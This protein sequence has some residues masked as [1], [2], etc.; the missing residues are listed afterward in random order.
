MQL[1]QE[2]IKE[3]HE[4]TDFVSAL[5]E[6]LTGYGIIASDF[7]GNIIAFNKGAHQIYGYTPLEVIGKRN[8]DIFLPEDFIN[9]GKLQKIIDNLIDK[10]NFSYEWEMVRK[11]GERF[12]S[13]VTFTL[14]WDKSGKMVG[15]ILI[16]EDITQ[17][18]IF[19]E[20]QLQLKQLETAHRQTLTGW[21]EGSVTAQMAGVGALRDRDPEVF[22]A[23]QKD[24]GTLLD[25]YLEDLAFNRDLPRRKIIELA[26]RIGDMGCGPRDV[27][28]I[29]MHVVEDKCREA[30]PKHARAY[31]LEGRLLTL[32]VMGNLVDYY[33]LRRT[34][35]RYKEPQ[36]AEDDK[37]IA[38]PMLVK[39]LPLP[40]RKLIGNL[41]DKDK[42]LLGLDLIMKEGEKK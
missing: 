21:K 35:R 5:F 1:I 4:N 3:L 42:V 6:S 41:S 23:L 36:L 15:F 25:V 38:T 11:N 8:I 9:T 34:N 10:G 26:D 12:P 20:G 37:I 18:K 19:E 30:N 28:D 39:I 24:Y 16:V 7:D 2:R 33:R 32:E 22:A 40:M 13:H 14:T 29:H 31:T 17:R 27:V